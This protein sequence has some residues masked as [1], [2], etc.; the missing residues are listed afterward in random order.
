MNAIR[1]WQGSWLL[2]E[3]AKVLN[4]NPLLGRPIA[5]RKEYRQLVLRVLNAAYVVQ[6]RVSG[7]PIVILRVYHGREERDR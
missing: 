7:D 3:K 2:L 5:G 1:P 4:G 6:Y